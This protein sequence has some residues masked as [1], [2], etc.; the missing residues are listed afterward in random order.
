M[1]REDVKSVSGASTPLI[2]P[3]PILLVGMALVA[4]AW[5]M[6]GALEGGLPV[7]RAVLLV[8]GVLAVGAALAAH[9]P[10]ARPDTEGRLSSAGMWLLATATLFVARWALDPAWDSIGLLLGVM[11]LVSVS[12]AVVTVLP[13]SLRQFAIS[14]L[15]LFHFGAIVD[16]VVVRPPNGKDPPWLAR[17]LWTRVYRP[18]LMFA[19]LDDPY[20]YLAPEPGPCT[21]LWFRVVFAD[22]T[23][24]WTRIPDHDACG[25]HV[26]RRRLAALAGAL[27]QTVPL[28]EPHTADERLYHERVIQRRLEA[29]DRHHP[30]IPPADTMPLAEQFREPTIE[31]KML[32]A[33]YVRHVA[34][35]TSHPQGLAAPV[36]SVKVYRAEYSGPAVQHFQAGRSPL[37]PA[38][39]QAWYQGEYE[40]DGRLRDNVEIVRNAQGEPVGR[41]QD[42]F[43]YWLIPIVR[44]A[45]MAAA[46]PKS[47]PG[48]PVGARRTEDFVLRRWSGEGKIINFVRIHAGDSSETWNLESVP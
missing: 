48:L 43:L 32:L 37:D 12:A 9:L 14:L 16:A 29:G 38:L 17:Q 19:Q 21:V 5:L 26:E 24:R 39:Y 15:I 25:S 13:R 45:D 31:A 40:P 27:G 6:G 11:M 42:P 34:R 8:L 4:A 36:A 22:G 28:P 23:A 7:L 3:F 47:L 33:S 20:H 30:P 10:Y 44:A 41:I 18:Y 46:M 35:T 2:P 1:D